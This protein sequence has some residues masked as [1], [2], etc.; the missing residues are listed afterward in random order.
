MWKN[1]C[2]VPKFPLFSLSGKSDNQIP[3]F[4][5]AVA[6]LKHFLKLPRMFIIQR[7]QISFVRA[8]HNTPFHIFVLWYLMHFERTGTLLSTSLPK[9]KHWSTPWK[10]ADLFHQNVPVGHAVV[11]L[12]GLCRGG[13]GWGWVGL[14]RARQDD[15][16]KQTYWGVPFGR[17]A[18][19]R[20][21]H[22]VFGVLWHDTINVC[23]MYPNV[24]FGIK[25]SLKV[26]FMFFK[27]YLL[28]NHILYLTSWKYL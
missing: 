18:A 19:I 4:L 14:G 1:P 2:V 16:I 17:H 22:F 12:G 7:F 6:T 25:L 10:R 13:T 20:L 21:F 5:C 3:C 27:F 23:D 11:G 15:L 8:L 9:G 28:T 26:F 24:K